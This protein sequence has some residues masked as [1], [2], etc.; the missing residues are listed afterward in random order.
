MAESVP[1]IIGGFLRVVGSRRGIS[2][3]PVEINAVAARVAEHPVDEHPDSQF[4][5]GGAQGTEILFVAQQRVDL[6]II[7][8]VVAV[9]GMG[10]ENGIAIQACDAQFFQVGQF[11]FNSLQVTA[12]KVGVGDFS[13]GVGSP[14]RLVRPI[15][16]EGAS[17]GD[18]PFCLSGFVKPVGEDLI[19]DPAFQPVGGFK[20]LVE[21][22]ELPLVI[23]AENAVPGKSLGEPLAAP[24]GADFKMIEVQPSGI[25]GEMALP[26][27]LIVAVHAAPEQV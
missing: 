21:H 7:R 4:F 17:V 6:G 13:L 11:F 24:A 9:V 15:L 16:V 1:G 27:F 3:L 26:P 12:E 10:F 8:R 23:A 25:R 5:R 14:V 2:S 22:G 20:I 18:L 19:H